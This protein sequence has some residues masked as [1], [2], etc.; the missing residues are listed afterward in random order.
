MIED[1]SQPYVSQGEGHRESQED[2]PR[3]DLVISP[4]VAYED[5]LWT[6]YA[7]WLGKGAAKYG[8]GNMRQLEGR[9]AEQHAIAAAFRHLHKVALEEND[10][11]HTAAVIANLDIINDVRAKRDRET[12]DA[13][14]KVDETLTELDD[15]TVTHE[16]KTDALVCTY[17]HLIRRRIHNPVEGKEYRIP[18]IYNPEAIL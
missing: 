9:E 2:K 15:R 11:D 10:E 3:F 7:V 6:R 1:N 14:K 12:I 4:N 17:C 5:Q 13:T 18:L 8:E 16:Y